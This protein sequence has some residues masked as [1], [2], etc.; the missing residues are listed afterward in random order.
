MIDRMVMVVPL[1]EKQICSSIKYGG[2]RYCENTRGMLSHDKRQ[3][4]DGR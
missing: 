4:T 1:L 2:S 3:M